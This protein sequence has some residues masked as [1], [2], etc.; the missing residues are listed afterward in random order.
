M[1]EPQR[2]YKLDGAP[3]AVD[4]PAGYEIELFEP[5]LLRLRPKEAAEGP[6]LAL[7][8]FWH[9]TSRNGYSIYCVRQGHEI[10]HSSYVITNNPRFGFMGRDDLEIGPCW[11]AE[12]RRGRG[13][14][15]AVLSRIARDHPGVRLWMFAGEGNVG[16][17]RG[18]ERAGF[19]AVGTGGKRRGVYRITGA[20]PQ[21]RD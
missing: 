2:F 15:P 9:L 21:A 12:S 17:Q 5:S 1:A 8:L 11:T 13:I 7:C 16:S 14:Y 10:V 4:L 18:I 20:V 19:E 3:A 6:P